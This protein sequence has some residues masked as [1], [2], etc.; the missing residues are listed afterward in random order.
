MFGNEDEEFRGAMVA[1]GELLVTVEVESSLSAYH[2]F[3]R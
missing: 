1:T 3:L 2:H